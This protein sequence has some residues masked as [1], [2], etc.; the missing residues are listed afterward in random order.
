MIEKVIPAIRLK[1]PDRGMNRTVVVQH[2]GVS[3]H[4]PEN[5]VEFNEAAKQGVWNICLETQSAKS[6]DT[7]VLDL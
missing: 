7:N 4:I 6:P 5:D 3:A 1:W 2:D